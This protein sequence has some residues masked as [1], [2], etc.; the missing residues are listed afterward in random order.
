MI[1]PLNINVTKRNNMLI[2]INGLQFSTFL[3]NFLH[4][5]VLLSE[6]LLILSVSIT[7]SLQY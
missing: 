2:P 4:F 7:H 5:I 3:I 1:I 6:I